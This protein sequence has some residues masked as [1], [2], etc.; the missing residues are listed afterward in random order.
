M[1]Y[2][3]YWT[4]TRSFTAVEWAI[5]S[6]DI[7]ALIAKS[8]VPIGDAHDDGGPAVFAFDH[9]AFNGVGADAH[10]TFWINRDIDGDGWSFC[11]T[12]RKPYDRIVVA[13]LIYLASRWD[14]KVD[15]DGD[16]ADWAGGLS[17]LSEVL[18]GIVIPANIGDS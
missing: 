13:C 18:P 17:L 7:A 1:G 8:G 4:Q 5:I 3:H 6:N 15:S 10:E 16:K 2:T 11:K 14:Y 9:I 12:A